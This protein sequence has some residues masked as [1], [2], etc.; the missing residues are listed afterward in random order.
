MADSSKEQNE[1]IDP[2][3]KES[4]LGGYM[5]QLTEIIESEEDT[6]TLPQWNGTRAD[7]ITAVDRGLSDSP[8]SP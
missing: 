8:P 5:R 6:R 1:S 4:T 3:T 7:P 2:L